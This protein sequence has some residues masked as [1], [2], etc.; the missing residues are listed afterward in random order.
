MCACMHM[1][2]RVIPWK[3]TYVKSSGKHAAWVG[4]P[5]A[6]AGNW[7]NNFSRKWE[8]FDKAREVN[9]YWKTMYSYFVLRLK[10]PWILM[11]CFSYIFLEPI[12]SYKINLP[13]VVRWSEIEIWRLHNSYREMVIGQDRTAGWI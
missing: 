12:R 5:R 13:V 7:N 2:V 1:Y 3:C 6:C 4:D 10:I 8:V 11:G 9:R